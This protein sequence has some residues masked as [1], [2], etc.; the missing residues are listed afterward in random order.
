MRSAGELARAWLKARGKRR[1]LLPLPLFGKVAARYRAGYN[2]A[3]ESKYG[4]I[5]WAEWLSRKYGAGPAA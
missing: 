1:L 4:R 3:P 5:T 2:C